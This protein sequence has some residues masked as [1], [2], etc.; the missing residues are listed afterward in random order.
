MRDGEFGAV[1]HQFALA[2]G[3]PRATVEAMAHAVGPHGLR[4]QLAAQAARPDSRPS[5][6]AIRVP[7]LVLTGA[8]DQI[9]PPQLQEELAAGIP[10]ARHAVIDGA[11]HMATLDAPGAV[12]AQLQHW[13]KGDT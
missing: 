2:N 7:T 4:R 13:L 10:G 12:A 6:G 1:A 11:G 5:L 9:C 3:G 8:D